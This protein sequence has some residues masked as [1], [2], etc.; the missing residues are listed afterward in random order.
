[1]I[2]IDDFDFK[3]KEAEFFGLIS[4]GGI[5]TFDARNKRYNFE[6][7]KVNVRAINHGFGYP[8]AFMLLGNNDST[9][10]SVMNVDFSDVYMDSTHQIT[11]LF[12]SM[13]YGEDNEVVVNVSKL[14]SKLYTQAV[15]GNPNEKNRTAFVLT[16]DLLRTSYYEF[17]FGEVNRM[18]GLITNSEPTTLD[19]TVVHFN[20]KSAD[21]DHLT[22]FGG[23]GNNG[24]TLKNNSAIYINCDDCT[25]NAS[26]LLKRIT[27][28]STSKV[29]ISGNYTVADSAFIMTDGDAN[30]ELKNVNV[31]MKTDEAMVTSLLPAEITLE[32][33]TTNS[34]VQ[35]SNVSYNGSLSIIESGFIPYTVDKATRDTW[36][37]KDGSVIFCEDCQEEGITGISQTY[38][39]GEWRNHYPIISSAPTSKLFSFGSEKSAQIKSDT[40]NVTVTFANNTWTIDMTNSAGLENIHLIG[41]NAD[42]DSQQRL[43]IEI[44]GGVGNYSYE[45]IRFP[46]IVKGDFSAKLFGD[47]SE[48]NPYNFDVDNNPQGKIVEVGSSGNPKL[49]IRYDGM[50]AFSKY[51][52]SIGSM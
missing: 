22:I 34:K 6:V 29:V 27:C 32:N 13:G 49:K 25:S 35:D 38:A 24:M 30:I 43:Y 50:N 31:T 47:P 12:R 11:S 23:V 40:D 17:N 10:N 39:Q 28:D 7:E 37:P 9:F 3:V 15:L 2:C 8:T 1:M 5:G 48:S 33:V 18:T 36:T 44:I 45:T 16:G 14:E 41:T 51:S 20:V 46:V 19:S 21:L 26:F 4:L 42:Y 52:F